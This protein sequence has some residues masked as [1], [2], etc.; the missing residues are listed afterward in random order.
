MATPL[1]LGAEDVED[2]MS[3]L[4]QGDVGVGY[5]SLAYAHSLADAPDLV[6]LP[7]AGGHLVARAIEP[8]LRDLANAYPM[9]GCRN[10]RALGP[11]IRAL[12][13]RFVSATIATDP[14][15]DVA[16]SELEAAFDI[17]RPL[18]QHFIVELDGGTS[19]RISRHHRRKLRT[20]SAATDVRIEIAPPDAS[21]FEHW[22]R[23][24]Q[25]LVERKHITDMRAFSQSIFARQIGTPAAS[26]RRPGAVVNCSV[27]TGISAMERM[28]MRISPPIP[29]RAMTVQC[30]IR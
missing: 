14:F 9:F 12:E 26:S 1:A 23:L 6:A 2:V 29:R 18:H 4:T 7:N 25:T 11:D 10:W 17:V 24:Y 22:V 3:V 19:S 30:L 20:A 28:S 15:A 5:A 21:L 16:L 27:P 13:G 8:G